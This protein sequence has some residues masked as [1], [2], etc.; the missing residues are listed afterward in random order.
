MPFID[1]FG[2]FF[3]FPS[4]CHPNTKGRKSATRFTSPIIGYVK[5]G[6]SVEQDVVEQLE[7]LF[8]T[9]R[10][11]RNGFAIFDVLGFDFDDVDTSMLSNF[12]REDEIEKFA[13]Q[14]GEQYKVENATDFAKNLTSDFIPDID[15]LLD[16]ARGFGNFRLKAFESQKELDD[17]IGSEDYGFGENKEGVCFAFAV[18]ENGENRNKYELELFF[19]DMWPRWLKSIPNQKKPV[20]NSYEYTY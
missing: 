4:Q 19:N 13:E 6:A 2:S 14:I 17:Y 18:H 10:Q 15:E 20:W 3:F 12:V 16:G 9:Q 5:T 7:S 11:M 1:P 8:R